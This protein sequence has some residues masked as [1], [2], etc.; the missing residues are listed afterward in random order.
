MDD[1]VRLL[2]DANKALSHGLHTLLF[3]DNVPVADEIDLK[4]RAARQRQRR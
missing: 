4:R 1:A 3:S 2:P